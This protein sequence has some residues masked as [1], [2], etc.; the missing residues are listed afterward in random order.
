[1][2]GGVGSLQEVGR[3]EVG[4]LQEVGRGEDAGEGREEAVAAGVV[5]V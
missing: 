2:G 5:A 1:M 3:G 4:S